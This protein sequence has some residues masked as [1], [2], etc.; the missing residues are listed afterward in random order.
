MHWW[1]VARIAA[2]HLLLYCFVVIYILAGASFF[3]YFE[4]EAETR[5]HLEQKKSIA[6]LKAD[7]FVRIATTTNVRIRGMRFLHV[8]VQVSVIEDELRHYLRIISARHINLE[9]YLL[10][11]DS[12]IDVVPRRWTFPSSVLF[13]FTILT[14]IGTVSQ[15]YP[16]GYSL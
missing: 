7:L 16:N 3:H 5:R 12:S 10:Y 11:T 4:G 1:H 14:T 2:G 8:D 13:A 9:N 15:M 6:E